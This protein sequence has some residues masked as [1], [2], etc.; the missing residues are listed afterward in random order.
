MPPPTPVDTSAK[1]FTIDGVEFVQGFMGTST[2]QQFVIT[3]Q[4][5]ILDAYVDLLGESDGRTMVELGIYAGGSTALAVLLG[6]LK[7]LIAVDL[8]E[9]E[10]ALEQF[11][12]DRDLRRSV[13][14]HYRLDQSD[15]V[16]LL[17]RVQAD[18]GGDSIDIVIDDASHLLPETWASFETLFPLLRPGGRYIIEDWCTSAVAVQALVEL[19][20]DEDAATTALRDGHWLFNSTLNGSL[21]SSSMSAALRALVQGDSRLAARARA[22]VDRHSLPLDLPIRRNLASIGADLVA[23]AGARPGVID[24]VEVDK[25][26]ISVTRGPDDLPKEGW[27]LLRHPGEAEVLLGC[28]PLGPVTNDQTTSPR[29]G[30]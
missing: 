22:V 5:P 27:T 18:L 20:D 10:L 6:N 9:P 3:K 13:H 25:N 24:R 28:G 16:E 29:F 14:T 4:G 23:V 8:S 26:W 1:T 2:P 15:R 30:S 7:R 21:I 17:A 19:L 12:D 11:L